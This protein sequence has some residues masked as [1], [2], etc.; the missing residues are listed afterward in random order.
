MSIAFSKNQVTKR[1]L[2]LL[3]ALWLKIRATGA[4]VAGIY[5]QVMEVNIAG[6]QA[7]EVTN[8]HDFHIESRI[9]Y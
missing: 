6:T 1:T 4:N 3:R 9:K 2:S 5:T 7:M 8:R